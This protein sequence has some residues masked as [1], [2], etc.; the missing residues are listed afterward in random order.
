MAVVVRRWLSVRHSLAVEMSTV[1][2]LYASY[3]AARGLV[4]GH[5]NVALRHAH[6]IAALERKLHLFVE[7][8][9][10]HAARGVPDLLT[11]FGAAY[12]TL[13]L[14]VSASVLLW[15]H[16]S[17]PAAYPRVRTTLLLASATA[18]LGFVVFPTAP[19]RMAHL[20]VLDTVSSGHVNLNHGLISQLY[21]P[22][23]AVPSMH[24]GYALV[25]SAVLVRCGRARLIRLAGMTYPLLVLLVVVATGNHFLFD[26]AAGALVAAAAYVTAAA[27]TI[28]AGA[29]QLMAVPA[30]PARTQRLAE[31][32][33]QLAA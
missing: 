14:G 13:H 8:N 23:A 5:R 28:D 18:L 26:A 17:H 29:P 3:E 6:T 2:V 25:V 20:G 21:N 10:Q 24:I 30:R 4:T 7:P 22:F 31:I 12:L 33:E 27:L 16:R 19:P 9:L 1:L 15:L 32:K 11:V